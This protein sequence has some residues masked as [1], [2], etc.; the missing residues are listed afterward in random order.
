MTNDD[1]LL[2]FYVLQTIV[3]FIGILFM[4]IGILSIFGVI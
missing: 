1:T 3:V 4:I 2:L